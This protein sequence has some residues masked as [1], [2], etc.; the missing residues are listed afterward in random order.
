LFRITDNAF[1]YVTE[2]CE[3]LVETILPSQ[4][5]DAFGLSTEASDY[6][7]VVNTDRD[8]TETATITSS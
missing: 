2:E 4:L 3:P 1:V 7:V 5:I 8:C 6:V